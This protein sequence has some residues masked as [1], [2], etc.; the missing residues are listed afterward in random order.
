MKAVLV[1]TGPLYALV[2][3]DD[4]YHRRSHSELEKLLD[5][6]ATL[7]IIFPVLFEAHT[8][9]MRRLGIRFS[10]RWLGEILTGSGLLNPERL[11]HLQAC[12]LITRY[13]DQPITLVDGLLAI[14]ATKLALEVWSYDHHFDVMQVPV[15]RPLNV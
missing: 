1:D 10:H 4:Q 2:D 6:G 13:D 7:S 12:E 3:P 14:L 11:D 9:V 5:T 8:L 15:W